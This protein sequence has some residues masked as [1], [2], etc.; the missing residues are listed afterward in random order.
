[1]LIQDKESKNI[2]MDERQNPV[3]TA[4]T[5][6]YY[7]EKEGLFST[8]EHN[9]KLYL[10]YKGFLKIVPETISQYHNLVALWL[11]N[12]SISKIEGLD[13]LIGL[14]SL[15][16][17]NN[18]IS[19]I[20]GLENL[21]NLAILNLSHNKVEIVEGLD[22]LRKLET[23]NLSHNFIVNPQALEGITVCPNLSTL[24]LSQN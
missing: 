14:T 23:L 16:L 12:N 9:D 3:M 22:S 24:D 5:L 1:M 20:E 17:N 10:Q 4:K 2:D 18:F 21:I 13:Q 7:C 19:R 11:N 6:R 8:P 15:A